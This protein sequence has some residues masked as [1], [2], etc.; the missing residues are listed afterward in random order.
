[1]IGANNIIS[2][3]RMAKDA[4]KKEAFD[5]TFVLQNEPAYIEPID[6]QVATILDGLNAFFMFKIYCEGKL[7]IRIGDKIT[8]QQSREYIVKGVEPYSNN[9]DTGDMTQM[10]CTLRFPS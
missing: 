3:K 4:E 2:V 6:A 7:D 1:M 5:S 9:G 10:I 8:D